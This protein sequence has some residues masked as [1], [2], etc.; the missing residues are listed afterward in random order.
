MDMA[1]SEVRKLAA[2]DYTTGKH[3]EHAAQQARQRNYQDFLIVDVDAHHYESE[4]Y[5]D[6]FE[7][8][9]NPVIR[10]QAVES[11]KRGG[12]ASM[13]FAPNE[14][15]SYLVA[16]AWTVDET[17][18]TGWLKGNIDTTWGSVPVRGNVGLQ[19]QHTDQSSTAITFNTSAPAAN[20]LV[21]STF[22][23]TYTDY[24]PSLNLAF[25][26]LA[27]GPWLRTTA[28]K[29]STSRPTLNAS[30]SASC[31]SNTRAGAVIARNSGA[32]AEIFATARPRLPCRRR[33]PPS[34]SN[35]SS[36]PRSTSGSS[37]RGGG[38]RQRSVVPSSHGSRAWSRSVPPCTQRMSSCSSPASSNSRMTNPS[39]PAA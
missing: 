13:T 34:R 1:R 2:D 8:I 10:R 16:K 17:I 4:S 33:R 6:V 37:D 27:R 25:M 23:K 14:N 29:S 22:G 31:D 9:E 30:S 20:Q 11:A 28:M 12:R 3:L 35:G 32:T 26:P 18:T 38:S 7:Y 15:A 21:P 39:P 36:M 24:L 5:K 19:V